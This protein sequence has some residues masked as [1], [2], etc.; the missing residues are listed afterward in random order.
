MA[1]VIWEGD[2]YKRVGIEGETILEVGDKLG[3]VTTYSDD[4]AK[5][6]KRG[7]VISNFLPEGTGLYAI[8]GIDQMEAIA[9]KIEAE[10]RYMKLVNAGS[11]PY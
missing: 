1:F 6:V 8:D 10:G 9:A 11:Y 4:E 7:D 5:R 3:E 2:K